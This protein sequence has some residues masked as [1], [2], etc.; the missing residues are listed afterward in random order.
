RTFDRALDVS[1]LGGQFHYPD[2]HHRRLRQTPLA[3]LSVACPAQRLQCHVALGNSGATAQDQAL[4]TEGK[5]EADIVAALFGNPHSFGGFPHRAVVGEQ[6][7]VQNAD[8][9]SDADQRRQHPGGWV[10]RALHLD[11]A[12][13]IVAPASTTE[14]ASR[15]SAPEQGHC[16]RGTSPVLLPLI[17]SPPTKSTAH[18][19]TRYASAA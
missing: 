12:S 16:Q 19:A 13:H 17:G 3:H 1:P 6:C 10:D 2:I 15:Q 9:V 18:W 14:A 11:T 8:D 5:F 7:S 4:S